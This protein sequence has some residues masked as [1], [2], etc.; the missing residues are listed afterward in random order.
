MKQ[1]TTISGRVTDGDG[2]P[3]A[4]IPVEAEVMDCKYGEVLLETKT[5]P[6]GYYTIS[7][8]DHDIPYYEVCAAIRP[9][10]WEF[11][12]RHCGYGEKFKLNVAPGATDVNF[13]LNEATA[14]LEGTITIPVGFSFEPPVA[15][16]DDLPFAYI[17]LQKK[18]VA[19]TE[20]MDGIEALS[21]PSETTSTTYSVDHLTP[22]TFRI[23][24][25]SKGLSTYVGEGTLTDGQ[26]TT[27]N[28]TLQQ[29]ATVSGTVTKPDGTY[30]TTSDLEM[31]VAMNASQELVFGSFTSD[32]ATGEISAY[33]IKGLKVDETYY[34]A[35]VSP[36]EDGPGDIYVQ[37]TTVSPQAASDTFS[38]NAVMT[39]GAPTF[40]LSAARS[41]DNLN[42]NIF[43]TTHLRDESASDMIALT[44]GE[45]TVSN[46]ILS[47]DKTMVSFTYEPA[48]D[49]T[50]L[51]FTLTGHYGADYTLVQQSYTIDLTVD[52]ANQG[53][54]NSF[55]GGTV[56]MGDGDA[57]GVYFEPGDL[58]DTD[59]NGKTVVDV[60][61][62]DVGAGSE[63]LVRREARAAG[64]LIAPE[65]VDDL[66][67]WATAASQQYEFSIGEDSVTAG[68]T[69]TV[70]LQYASGS[71]TDNLHVL[72]YTG[73]AWVVEDT[74]VTLDTD[75]RTISVEVTS[76]SPFV[77]VE[78]TPD[79]SGSSSSTPLLPSSS[80]GGTCFID[81]A[82]TGGAGYVLSLL[83]MG[84]ALLIPARSRN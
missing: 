75:N 25:M 10:P 32:P 11:H 6:D 35:L 73:G 67:A 78:G 9:D 44:T 51:A 81:T 55:M 76:L 39:E 16:E 38:L 7:G 22:G 53:L 83:L 29:G 74:N 70:T 80:G 58:E 2:N 63:A 57:S 49:E 28:I 17:V 65:A 82:A 72:H 59:D 26:T 77:A 46:K 61:K 13:Q 5:G 50:T 79:D 47:P 31:P 19:Y 21:Q 30:P 71:D 41:G 60:N 69:V 8:V 27:L 45:G 24:A 64:T 42:I 54:V 66:P 20:P 52:G 36:G 1:G 3:L 62:A 43:S 14:P 12:M 23:M 40:M 4:N 68:S 37:A 15:E 34:V 56:N 18:G 84:L 33:E 48:A